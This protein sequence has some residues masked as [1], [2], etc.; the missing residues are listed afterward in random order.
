M[1]NITNMIGCDCFRK[2][3]DENETEPNERAK[4]EEKIQTTNFITQKEPDYIPPHSHS[5]YIKMPNHD[6]FDGKI[7]VK[8]YIQK[9]ILILWEIT[10]K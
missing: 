2:P 10:K 5:L 6:Y 3:E 7:D 4:L 8:D 1:G 9:E